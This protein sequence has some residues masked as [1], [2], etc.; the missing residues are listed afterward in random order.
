MTL[1]TYYFITIFLLC[2]FIFSGCKNNKN[3]S[4]RSL[5]AITPVSYLNVQINDDF[6]WPKIEKNRINGIRASFAACDYSLKNFDIAAGKVKGKHKGTAA[7]DSDV[8]KLIQGA[9]YALHNQSDEALKSFID[10]LIN[11]IIAAQQ[12]DGYLYTFWTIN[13]LEQRWKDIERK[14]ELYCAGHMFEAAVAYYEVTGKRSFLDAAIRLADHID[15]V[16]GPDK[17]R[18]VPGHQEI[19]LALLKL[20]QATDQQK[21]LHLARFFLEERGNPERLAAMPPKPEPDP[22]ANTP[23]RWRPPSYRQDHLPLKDQRHA[24][25]HAVRAAYTYAAMTD[26][27]AITDSD[28]YLQALDSIW[29][30]IVTKKLYITGAIG[31]AEKHDEGFGRPYLLPNEKAY[32]ETCANIAFL[33]WNHRMNL[34]HGSAKYADLVELILFNAGISGVSFSGDHYFYRNPLQSG[35]KRQRSPWFEPGC[36]PSNIARFLPHIGN[37]IYGKDRHGIYINQFVSSEAEIVFNQNIIELAT[38]TDFPWDG[39]VIIRLKPDEAARFDLYIRF[40]TWQANSPAPGGLYTYLDLEPDK[41]DQIKLKINSKEVAFKVSESGYITLN[42]TWTEND[43]IEL[44]FNLPIRR[45]RSHPAIEANTGKVALQRGPVI[46]CLEEIDNGPELFDLS[47]SDDTTLFTK[48]QKDLLGGIMTIE[49]AG[50]VAVPY[51][52]WANRGPGKMLIWIPEISNEN[53]EN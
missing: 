8:Y 26:F 51:F 17:R 42:R 35:G 28:I 32:C 39:K 48:F 49:G 12:P 43:M 50:F 16:F 2:G 14:H 11:R 29:T 52:A 30:D 6:W 1:Y 10:S 34:L 40:P 25:G 19:E 31:T 38:V 33:F 23:R 47:L 24:T 13:D 44:Q 53:R 21:Y 15:S 5:P 18:E 3:F 41:N 45:I 9:A 37:Y 7:S 27:M 46:F 36:C 22:H 4:D 20:Y